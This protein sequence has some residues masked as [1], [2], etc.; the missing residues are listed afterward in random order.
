[1]EVKI[2]DNENV[3]TMLRRFKKQLLRSGLLNTARKKRFYEKEVSKN[4]NK[5]SALKKGEL[6]KERELL[7]KKGKIVD[8]Y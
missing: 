2:K 1:M 4:L 8:K 7:K 5:K 6:R 3:E